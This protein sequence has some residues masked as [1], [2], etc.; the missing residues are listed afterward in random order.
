MG[1]TGTFVGTTMTVVSSSDVHVG[2]RLAKENIAACC[3]AQHFREVLRR[4]RWSRCPSCALFL[5]CVIMAAEYSDHLQN[6]A[7]V[8]QNVRSQHFGLG[9]RW[10]RVSRRN[11]F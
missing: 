7:R 1:A 9:H 8:K 3:T 11:V 2:T 5:F 6:M 10:R 4:V